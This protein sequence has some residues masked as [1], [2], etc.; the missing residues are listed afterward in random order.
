LTNGLTFEIESDIIN[1]KELLKEK[2]KQYKKNILEL[3]NEI[4]DLKHNETYKTIQEIDDVDVYFEELK[5]ELQSEKDRL[6]EEA[7]GILENTEENVEKLTLKNK[8]EPEISQY[9]KYIQSI[10]NINF[11]KIRRYCNNL[12]NDNKADDMQEYLANNGKMYKAFIYDS[13]EQ[14]VEKLD[15]ENITLL[16]WECNQGLGSILVL[17]YVKEK[18]LDIKISQVILIDEDTKALSRAIAQVNALSYKVDILALKSC[19]INTVNNSLTIQNNIT[20]NLIANNKISIVSN[21]VK[22]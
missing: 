2:I 17:D 18:Q 5:S 15:G 20:L 6:E 11:E 1:D 13:L 3:G 9:S 4:K 7:K 10:E 19:D 8:I 16:D 21:E 12:L 14:F 22:K